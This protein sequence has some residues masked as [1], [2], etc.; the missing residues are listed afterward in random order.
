[1]NQQNNINQSGSINNSNIHSLLQNSQVN[2][3]VRDNFV[4]VT[5]K[6]PQKHQNM[7]LKCLYHEEDESFLYFFISWLFLLDNMKN[8][9]RQAIQKK[10][11]I[12]DI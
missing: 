8:K 1:M 3:L 10:I 7:K 12:L 11:F 4:K 6:N 5:F 2:C 9:L